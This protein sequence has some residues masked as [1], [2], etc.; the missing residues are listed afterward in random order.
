MS[1]LRKEAYLEE[2]CIQVPPKRIRVPVAG[3][4]VLRGE[5]VDEPGS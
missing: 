4:G 1:Q 5:V 3:A 2:L